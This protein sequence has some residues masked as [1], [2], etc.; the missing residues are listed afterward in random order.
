[1]KPISCA[2][3]VLGLMGGCAKQASH[4]PEA[5]KGPSTAE[6]MVN[7]LTG[8]TAVNAGQKARADITRISEAHNRDLNQ[9]TE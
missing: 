9:I 5:K 4:H 7:G 6:T 8:R 3:L 2:L 1:M